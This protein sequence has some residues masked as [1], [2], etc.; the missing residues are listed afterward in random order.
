MEGTQNKSEKFMMMR[1]VMTKQMPWNGDEPADKSLE[2]LTLFSG[3][4]RIFL[5]AAGGQ[6]TFGTTTF[7]IFEWWLCS[8]CCCDSRDAEAFVVLGGNESVIHCSTERLMSRGPSLENGRKKF[9]LISA[10]KVS[11]KYVSKQHCVH[12][13][14]CLRLA[15][16]VSAQYFRNSSLVPSAAVTS[17]H[18]RR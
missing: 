16:K 18:T 2:T 1:I 12:A 3:F 14:F 15:S 17:R 13:V 6:A 11:V 4:L 8:C 10:R 5:A 9:Q 7:I